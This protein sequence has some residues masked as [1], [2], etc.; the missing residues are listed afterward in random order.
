MKTSET[1]ELL[2]WKRQS[3][4]IRTED[5]G[6]KETNA[7]PSLSTL[8]LSSPE[9]IQA[10]VIKTRS[11]ENVPREI[12]CLEEALRARSYLKA[13]FVKRL[14]DQKA[15]QHSD[16]MHMRNFNKHSMFVGFFFTL[17]TT[18]RQM[19]VHHQQNHTPSQFQKE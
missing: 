19:L 16:S 12:E 1:I 18:L 8:W 5:C 3:T 6:L 10:A 9:R 13:A 11:L 14:Q 15:R 7:R 4:S 2:T 17:S